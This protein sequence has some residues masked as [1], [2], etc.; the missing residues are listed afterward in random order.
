MNANI[1]IITALQGYNDTILQHNYLNYPN[2]IR[3]IAEMYIEN[4]V[5]RRGRGIDLL[6]LSTRRRG[7]RSRV[8]RAE[9]RE[10]SLSFSGVVAPPATGGRARG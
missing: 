10:R 2:Y 5:S 3:I 6:P 7:N 9:A 4:V 1:I 8:A